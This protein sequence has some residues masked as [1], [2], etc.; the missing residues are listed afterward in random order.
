MNPTEQYLNEM[1]MQEIGLDVGP[2]MRL[3]DQD[4]GQTLTFKGKDLVAPNALPNNNV[5]VFDCYNSTALMQMMFG[6][7]T[8]KYE[9]DNGVS[10]DRSYTKE[11]KDGKCAMTII[12]SNNNAIT[13]TPYQRD[14]LRYMDLIMRL[15]GDESPDLSKYDVGK[16]YYLN[17]KKVAPK[18]RKR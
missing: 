16:T 1:L 12:D 10:I 15:N 9:E 7:Y 2:R 8:K 17:G 5:V 6:F 4:T 3:L 14:T 11:V 13:S 18:R